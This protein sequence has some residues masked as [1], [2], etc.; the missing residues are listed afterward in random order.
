L[1]RKLIN[2]LT[3]KTGE[4]D[5]YEIDTALRPNGNSGMLV[6]SFNAYSNYQQQ[7]GSNTAWTWEHQA[8]TRARCVLGDAVLHARFDRVRAAVIGAERDSAGLREEI[9]SMRDKVRAAHPVRGGN[10]DVKHSPGGMVDVEFAVQFLVLAQGC[11]HPELLANA[12]NIALLQR[13]Q[14]CGLLPAPVGENA[15]QAYRTLRQI[16]HRARLNEEPTQVDQAVVEAERAAG[17][18]LWEV[19]FKSAIAPES[20]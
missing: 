1:V 17:L 19:V 18:A 16:Q 5:L 9:G 6:T 8:M 3:V 10:F 13:A 15:A 14:A 2:W 7:R 12:G 20:S 11:R 4:G